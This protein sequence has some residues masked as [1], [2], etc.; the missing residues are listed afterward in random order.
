MDP[1][2]D[3]GEVSQVR[4]NCANRSQDRRSYGAN[5]RDRERDFHECMPMLIPY[6]DAADIARVDHLLNF[7][8]Q[9]FAEDFEL[10][11]RDAKSIHR[12][13]YQCSAHR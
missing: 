9:L 4:G 8:H 1:L 11:E 5:R 13:S 10:F 3:D 12:I 6:D 7:I 2:D